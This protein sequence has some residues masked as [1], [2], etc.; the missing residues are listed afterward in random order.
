MKFIK[1]IKASSYSLSQNDMKLI[2]SSMISGQLQ[3]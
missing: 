1:E 3:S 2:A